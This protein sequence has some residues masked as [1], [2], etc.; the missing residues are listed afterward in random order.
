MQQAYGVPTELEVVNGG[1]GFSVGALLECR[2][3]LA[4][5]SSRRPSGFT[6]SVA[7]AEPVTGCTL[8]VHPVINTGAAKY[9]LMTMLLPAAPCC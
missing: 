2:P 8:A 4:G 7:G 3:K 6:A 5:S 1:D 9:V